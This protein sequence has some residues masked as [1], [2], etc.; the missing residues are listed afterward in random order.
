[1]ARFNPDLMQLDDGATGGRRV[2][3]TPTDTSK[4]TEQEMYEASRQAAIE[5]GVDPVQLAREAG[6]AGDY[7]GFNKLS[8]AE[9]AAFQEG[10]SGQQT[11]ER[12]FGTADNPQ[13]YDPPPGTNW[14]LYGDTWSLYYNL[15]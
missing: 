14:N 3:G 2:A 15:K 7:S 9:K 6:A 5:L 1:M 10:R 13:P 8:P 11:Q 4:I 12:K